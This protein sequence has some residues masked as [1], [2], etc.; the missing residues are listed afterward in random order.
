[1][2]SEMLFLISSQ[3]RK[4]S[5]VLIHEPRCTLSGQTP[6][7]LG[8]TPWRS[9]LNVTTRTGQEGFIK[10]QRRAWG[11][12]SVMKCLSGMH[13]ALRSNPGSIKRKQENQPKNQTSYLLWSLWKCHPCF[14][15]SVFVIP[16]NFNAIFFSNYNSETRISKSKRQK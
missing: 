13:R 3:T 6:K 4:N 12:S 7:T 15:M 14:W 16:L 10:N 9:D 8:Q 1:M 5:I 2:C 11:C